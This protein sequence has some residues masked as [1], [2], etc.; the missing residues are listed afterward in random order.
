M[1]D[2]EPAEQQADGRCELDVA[3]AEPAAGQER[4]H[5]VGQGEPEAA[6]PCDEQAVPLPRRDRRRHEQQREGRQRRPRQP[7]REPVDVDVDPDEADR[8][9][10][11]EQVCRQRG[12]RGR[13][14]DRPGQERGPERR[15]RAPPTTRA[16]SRARLVLGDPVA[17]GGELRAVRWPT[18]SAATT[19]ST[20]AT[21]GQRGRADISAPGL[22]AAANMTSSGAGA[23]GEE[24]DLRGRLVDEHVQPGDDVGTA[25][26]SG[27]GQRGRPVRID[28]IQ[29][30][31]SRRTSRSR[32]TPRQPHA[33]CRG[34]R[35]DDE[36][37]GFVAQRSSGT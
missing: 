23:A 27:P 8:E 15:A 20:S 31:A 11:E 30:G 1:A 13:V 2:R 12:I 35:R 18:A 17:A 19:R 6:Q 4:E 9:P 7:H 33:R 16:E 22:E 14:T 24:L 28:D 29:E 21:H 34:Q 32:P 37:A 3:A 36:P 5:D 10:G 25:V 26:T